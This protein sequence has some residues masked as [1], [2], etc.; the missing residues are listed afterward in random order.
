MIS[1]Y[2]KS[3]TNIP[4]L[5]I[6]LINSSLG[7]KKIASNFSRG[8]GEKFIKR[9]RFNS[10]PYSSKFTYFQPPEEVVNID[11]KS[12]KY[13]L[14]VKYKYSMRDLFEFYN[15]TNIQ[16]SKSS[17]SFKCFIE[18]VCCEKSKDISAS[19]YFSLRKN[20]QEAMKE[21]IDMKTPLTLGKNEK[22]II[23]KNNPLQEISINMK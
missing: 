12:V 23:P 8:S 7:P 13:S 16:I 15:K 3:L 4:Y 14:D 6:K 21:N 22:I 20:S 18:D 5:T 17:Q 10:D 11:P 9:E 2:L 1:V 19:S